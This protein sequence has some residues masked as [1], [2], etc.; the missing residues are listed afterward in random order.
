MAT[1]RIMLLGATGQVGQALRA[2]PMPQDWQLAAFGRQECDITDHRAVK[3]KIH[4]IK[5]DIVINAAA[6]TAVD[7]CE[8][9]QDAAMAANFDGP[10]NL[11]AQCSAID[12]PLIHLS[13]DYVFD[14][15]ESERPYRPDDAMS[16]LSVYGH[17]KMMG[18]EAIRHGHPWHVILRISSVFSA[19]GTNLLT[20]MIQS[21]ETR[22]ELKIVTDQK[23]CP[24]P[25]QD[26]ARGIIT[27]AGA[28]LGGKSNGFGTFHLCGTPAAV[29]IEFMQAIMDAYAPYTARRPKIL[30]ALSSDFPGFAERP[31]YS[32]L[33]CT[34]TR[35]IY[36]IE[37]RPWR[38][39][40]NEAMQ[41][42]M[43]GRS[44]VA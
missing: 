10:A 20:K 44:K 14:G 38:D 27:I 22:D 42:L 18:E 6:M 23:S 16:P 32:A 5:P 17:S 11:A 29:R 7:K 37:Q 1:K 43:Q 12:A 25:A 15:T 19:Y 30:P 13:T 28:I 8:T 24:T 31:A 4:T 40:L 2:E 34:K 3:D 36:G 21:I 9:E 26:V 35:E 39:G 33:D 41:L